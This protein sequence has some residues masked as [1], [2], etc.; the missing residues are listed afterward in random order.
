MIS[1]KPRSREFDDEGLGK[2]RDYHHADG[3]RPGPFHGL[4]LWFEALDKVKLTRLR[5]EKRVDG[6]VIR[7][8]KS[9]IRNLGCAAVGL[10]AVSILAVKLVTCSPYRRLCLKRSYEGE[11]LPVYYMVAEYIMVHKLLARP[12][13]LS[14]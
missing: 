4:K 12:G 1:V 8:P 9:A 11:P 5:I 13:K 14:Q 3:S 2:R 7:N 10:N 6:F